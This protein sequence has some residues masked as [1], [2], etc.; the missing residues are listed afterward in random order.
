MTMFGRILGNAVLLVL[1]AYFSSR[2]I[3]SIWKLS[4]GRIGLAVKRMSTKTATYPVMT[5]CLH[6]EE[7]MTK[8]PTANDSSNLPEPKS[9]LI[10]SLTYHNG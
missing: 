2:V 9:G 3:S 8:L 5:F 7:W 10:K 1:F 4:K 6:E